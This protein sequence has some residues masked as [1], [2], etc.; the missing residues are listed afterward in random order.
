V[1]VLQ[2]FDT[3]NARRPGL[4]LCVLDAEPLDHSPAA[5]SLLSSRG[6][7]SP[8]RKP[9]GATLGTPPPR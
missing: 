9:V 8:T 3:D 2:Y 5:A 4:D 7:S 6:T 1:N